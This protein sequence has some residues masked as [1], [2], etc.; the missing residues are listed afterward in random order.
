MRVWHFL[1]LILILHSQQNFCLDQVRCS[2]GDL[3][4]LEES[5]LHDFESPGLKL[6]IPH[7]NMP[8]ILLHSTPFWTWIWANGT[9][10][11]GSN[12][13]PKE[14]EKIQQPASPLF[15]D[16]QSTFNIQT[17]YFDENNCKHDSVYWK[18]PTIPIFHNP[19]SIPWLSSVSYKV[20]KVNPETL[21]SACAWRTNSIQIHRLQTKRQWREE[22]V[23]SLTLP[24]VF[25][26][27]LKQEF[28]LTTRCYISQNCIW[29]AGRK[30]HSMAD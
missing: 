8:L 24:I 18:I 21:S 6:K 19:S 22:L 15:H 30:P 11:R 3:A 9:S 20:V 14:N 17:F 29:T 7:L 16:R 13:P 28:G 2:H 10:W 25:W 12:T 27:I 1:W 23:A 26:D 4:R 5:H